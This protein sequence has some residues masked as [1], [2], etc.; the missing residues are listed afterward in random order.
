MILDAFRSL[1]EAFS[2]GLGAF[3]NFS[4]VLGALRSFFDV[5]GAISE[6]LDALRSFLGGFRGR[7]HRYFRF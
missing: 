1:L 5:F 2:T 6:V 7:K 3:R 4:V